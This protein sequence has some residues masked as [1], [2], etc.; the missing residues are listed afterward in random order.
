MRALKI[1]I[2][3]NTNNYPYFLAEGFRSLGHDVQLLVT[4]PDLLHRPESIDDD[5]KNGYPEWIIDAAVADDLDIVL[6]R[7]DI[8]LQ[9]RERSKWADLTILNDLGPSMSD[10]IHGPHVAFM[11]GSDLTYYADL[12]MP[13]QRT[14][15]WNPDYAASDEAERTLLGL[16]ALVRR[17]RRGIASSLHVIYP[18]KGLSPD[19]DQILEELGVEPGRR[20][21]LYFMSDCAAERSPRRKKYSDELKVVSGARVT[22]ESPPSPRLNTD[23]THLDVDH[24]HPFGETLYSMDQKGADILI[25]GFAKYCS[26]E[27][28]GQLWLPLKG[29]SVDAAKALI[30][31][32]KIVDRVTW[33]EQTSHEGF[34]NLLTSADLVCDQFG[35]SF[36]GMVTLHAFRLGKPVMANFR[37][38]VEDFFHLGLHAQT[39]DQISEALHSVSRH[40]ESLHQL[41]VASR[42]FFLSNLTSELAA[43]QLL[44]R[45]GYARIPIVRTLIRLRVPRRLRVY[46]CIVLRPANIPRRVARLLLPKAVRDLIYRLYFFTASGAQVLLN[47]PSKVTARSPDLKKNRLSNS[48]QHRWLGV[49]VFLRKRWAKLDAYRPLYSDRKNLKSFGDKARILKLKFFAALPDYVFKKVFKK[50]ALGPRNE[51]EALKSSSVRKVM[52][53]IGT[54]GPGGAEKQLALT[55]IGLKSLYGIEV[56]VCF[57]SHNQPANKFFYEQIKKAGVALVDLSV[58]PYGTSPSVPQRYLKSEI[59]VY[60]EVISHLRPDVVHCW[61]DHVN[62][63]AGTAAVLEGVPKVILGGRSVSPIHFPL[64]APFMREGYRWLLSLPSVVLVNN[65]NHG[66]R[67]YEEW[68]GLKTGS[69]VVVYNGVETLDVSDELEAATFEASK[70]PAGDGDQKQKVVGIFRFS[71]EK[72]P[73]L[74]L[75]VAAAL[76]QLCKDVHFV[77]VGDGPMMPEVLAKARSLRLENVLELKGN[78]KNPLSTIVDGSL[79]MLT[80]R[81]EGLPNVLLEAQQHGLPVISVDIGGA[82]ETM[83]VNSTGRVIDSDRPEEIAREVHDMLHDTAWLREARR[84]G[85]RHIEE[86]FTV[87]KML[88]STLV[89]YNSRPV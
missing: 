86:N 63:V 62:V 47:F 6:G 66:A 53:V 36:P 87:N 20:T 30:Q 45:V 89:L 25:R 67:D 78:V 16:W 88:E 61:L 41:G 80:S 46:V 35:K 75:E 22:F 65:S 64:H 29:G 33:Y 42:R 81:I 27:G 4:K 77:L 10:A 34:E 32:L 1:L 31:D 68:L 85:R 54:L 55:A 24:A 26:E 18:R 82:R 52:L 13:L 71:E 40:P 38:D 79:L 70:S 12:Q 60:R 9:L 14:Q 15:H 39:A 8:K 43:E 48:S 50:I 28:K 56:T 51:P 5:L 21:M 3:G 17:Q 7:S 84:Y 83:I 57:R 72:R 76:R 11:T 49:M 58:E 19:G 59:Q 44:I 23:A 74:W 37:L 69:I 73:L 2:Y